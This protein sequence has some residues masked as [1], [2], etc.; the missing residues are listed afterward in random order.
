MATVGF[1]SAIIHIDGQE[2]TIDATQGGAINAS[3]SGLGAESQTEYASNIPFLITTQGVSDVKCSLEVSDILNVEGLYNQLI[4]VQTVNGISVVGA[5]TKPPYV[6]LIL[7]SKAKMSGKRMFMGLTKG[8]FVHPDIE[9]GTNENSAKS[10]TDKVEG[11]FISDSRGFVYMS[12]I[13]DNT[14]V[15]LA[16]FKETLNNKK[17][18]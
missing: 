6:S 17:A 9:L 18:S 11:T 14:A 12:A 4:G 13:E 2:F 8:V 3:I 15:T 5:D 16:K 10:T 7:I 1:D